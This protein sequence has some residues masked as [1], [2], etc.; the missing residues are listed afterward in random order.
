MSWKSRGICIEWDGGN[1]QEAALEADLRV[2]FEVYYVW[3][4][5]EVQMKYT[6]GYI[7]VGKSEY[8]KC[9]CT[10]YISIF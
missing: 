4:A 6:V 9:G 7:W 1:G 2:L 10:N 3:D 5:C 8:L